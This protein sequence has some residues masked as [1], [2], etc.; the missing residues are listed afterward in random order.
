MQI[1]RQNWLIISSSKMMKS[2]DLTWYSI[3]MFS[4]TLVR[5]ECRRLG[6]NYDVK[7]SLNIQRGRDHG[8]APYTR[9]EHPHF[10]WVLKYSPCF[11][12]RK[13]CGLSPVT[14]WKMLAKIFPQNIVPRLQAIY[15]K[16]EDV[17]LFVG[18]LLESAEEVWSSQNWTGNITDM[19]GHSGTHFSL[20]SWWPV[21]EA[22]NW[23]SVIQFRSIF[24]KYPIGHSFNLSTG[25]G[26]RTLVIRHSLSHS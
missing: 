24:D 19:S 26:M 13:L 17:D 8:L 20:L 1:C 21:P 9:F 14:S 23:R 15:D 25:F 22:Q 16:V 18:G 2:L 11:S 6:G 7:V 3:I 10:S 12:W 4:S 5:A